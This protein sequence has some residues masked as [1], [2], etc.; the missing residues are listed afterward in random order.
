MRIPQ[1]DHATDSLLAFANR[2]TGLNAHRVAPGPEATAEAIHADLLYQHLGKHA[3]ATQDSF[4]GVCRRFVK[5][6]DKDEANTSAYKYFAFPAIKVAAFLESERQRHIETGNQP[7]LNVEHAFTE[8][9]RLSFIQGCPLFNSA[10]IAH[11]KSPVAKSKNDSV[12]KHRNAAKRRQTEELTEED[13]HNLLRVCALQ[14]KPLAAAQAKVIVR[15]VCATGF[16]ACGMIHQTYYNLIRD[17]PNL[18]NTAKPQQL[19]IV[20]V[21]IKKHKTDT[22]GKVV[23]TGLTRHPMAAFGELLALEVQLGHLRLLEQIKNREK[24]WDRVKI[25]FPGYADKSEATQTKQISNLLNR[26]TG[27]IKGWNKSKVT[28]LLCKKCTADLRASGLGSATVNFHIGW[29]GGTQDRSYARESLQSDMDA[30]AKAA[31]FIKDVR[32]HHY[33][34]RADV[35][36]PKA[37]YDVLLPGLTSLLSDIYNLPAGEQET[38][39]CIELFVQAFWQALPITVLK[40]GPEFTKKQLIGVQEVMQTSAFYEFDVSV[41]QAELDS[42]DKLGLRAPYLTKWAEEYC[43]SIAGC[44]RLDRCRQRAFADSPES[45]RP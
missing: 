4:K 34:G 40:Y 11:M 36:V 5:W 39:Q 22:T 21:G 42:M 24:D 30:Q 26:I 8:M 44:Q 31:G 3:Q 10:E 43:S 12:Q 29:N 37:W 20:G 1:D 28:G 25:L 15:A 35:C 6:C 16:R 17:V 14:N 2:Y 23:F 45:G 41:K 13:I 32:E 18:Y 7:G 9:N 27:Q 33:V 19:D 38:L